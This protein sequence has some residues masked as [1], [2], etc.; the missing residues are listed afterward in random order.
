M[1]AYAQNSKTGEETIETIR[2]WI[3][4]FQ[5]TPKSM[6]A[7]MAFSSPEFETFFKGYKIR[8]M[9]TG[10]ATPWPNRAEAANRLF[11]RY[12][13]AYLTEID[14]DPNLRALPPTSFIRR[15]ATARNTTVTF[16]GNTVGTCHG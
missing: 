4:T 1:W 6:C 11:K 8:P 10:A 14:K 13:E 16:G 3:E 9:L 12:L 5:C 15:A 2:E 7:D